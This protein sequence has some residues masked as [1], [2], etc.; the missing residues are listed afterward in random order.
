MQLCECG[1]FFSDP[2]HRIW[3]DIKLS[4]QEAGLW[5][6]VYERLHCENLPC[7]PFKS[8]AWWRE[9]QACMKEHFRNNTRHNPL[10][11]RLY[12]ELQ[13]EARA[14]GAVS[15]PNDTDGA[16]VDVWEWLR[17]VSKLT[18]Q[19][20]LTKTKTWFEPFVVISKGLKIHTAYLCVLCIPVSY[21]HLTLP[22]IYSV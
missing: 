9:M 21:T 7:G 4:L 2:F 11:Q 1:F 13:A 10:F 22:T 18:R 12:P 19:N 6:D 5:A 16:A 3:N 14:A 15:S 17:E 20:R 8:A